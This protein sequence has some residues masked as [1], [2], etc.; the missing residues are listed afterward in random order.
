MEIE[1]IHRNNYREIAERDQFYLAR[2]KEL[3]TQNSNLQVTLNKLGVE[4][5]K[6]RLSPQ[7]SS[8]KSDQRIEEVLEVLK[9]AGVG[10]RVRNAVFEVYFAGN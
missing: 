2:I 4:N 10:E 8:F 6:L 7:M 1:E 5:Q 9:A 3:E